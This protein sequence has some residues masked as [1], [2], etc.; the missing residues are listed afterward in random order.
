[1]SAGVALRATLESLACAAWLGRQGYFAGLAA[2]PA[3]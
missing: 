2:A 1:M 3:Q